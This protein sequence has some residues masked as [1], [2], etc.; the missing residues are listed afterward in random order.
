M[1]EKVTLSKIFSSKLFFLVGIIILIFISI[2]LGKEVLRRQAVN[3]DIGKLQSEVDA[4]AARNA[5]LADLIT[6]LNSENWQ[7][8]EARTKLNLQKPGETIVITSENINTS[9]QIEQTA[10]A[11]AAPQLPNPQ[12]WLNYF[13]N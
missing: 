9:S 3:A 13:I 12:K 11:H 4:L 1:K 5:E 8:R 2:S 6:Y 7:E 10:T